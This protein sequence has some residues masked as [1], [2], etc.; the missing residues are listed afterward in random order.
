MVS[1]TIERLDKGLGNGSIYRLR[2]SI[3]LRL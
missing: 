1:Y 3:W 2:D